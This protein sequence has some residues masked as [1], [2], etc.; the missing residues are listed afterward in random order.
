MA[1][2][3]PFLKFCGGK[4]AIL[5]EILP[6]LPKKIKTYYEPFVGGGAVF[7]ALAAEGIQSS[8][9][10]IQMKSSCAAAIV[11]RLVYLPLSKHRY[12][13]KHYYQ[14]VRKILDD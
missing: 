12:N 4:A 8:A 7:F 1:I 14:Y 11:I 3:K 5:P 6:R 10:R 9:Y 2:A 13:E